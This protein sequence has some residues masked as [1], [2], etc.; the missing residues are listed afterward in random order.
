MPRRGS[1]EDERR[2]RAHAVGQNQSPRLH[3]PYSDSHN[4]QVRVA[5]LPHPVRAIALTAAVV[6]AVSAASLLA[7]AKVAA[8]DPSSIAVKGDWIDCNTTT[9]SRADVENQLIMV[10]IREKFTGTL[11]GTFEGSE[12]NV[13]HKDGA[14][15]FDGSGVFS[16]QINSRS[17]T[18]IMT[19]SGTVNSKGE[20][21]AH[22]VLDHGTEDLARIDGHGTFEGKQ[23][24]TPPADLNCNGDA[25]SAFSGTYAGTVM[26]PPKR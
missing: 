5:G 26:L 16:G 3:K 24:K 20:A 6:A 23:L 14:G 9:Q 4:R 10:A 2:C 11:N 7:K 12:R 22:W 19:Y 1:S 25:Q 21:V 15:T 13:V 8:A 17:G 18:A